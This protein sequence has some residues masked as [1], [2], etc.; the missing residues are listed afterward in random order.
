MREGVEHGLLP[1]RDPLC[2]LRVGEQRRQLFVEHA[3]VG[4]LPATPFLDDDAPLL[5]D[6]LR[7]EGHTVRP[8]FE[9]LEGRLHDLGRVGGDGEFVD[10]LIKAGVGV[11]VGADTQT[12]TFEIVPQFLFGEVSCA[13]ER[14]VLDEMGQPLLL[15]GLQDRPYVESQT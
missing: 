12:D 3:R 6:L 2:V 9:N 14:H 5:V 11:E 15:V 1:D 10:G 8:V 7:F 13:V 4:A